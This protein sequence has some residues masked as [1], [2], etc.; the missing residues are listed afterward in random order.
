MGRFI[1]ADNYPSTG[2]DILGN[3]MFAYCNNNPVIYRDSSGNALDTVIDV[4]SLFSSIVA[5]AQ[6]PNDPWAWVGLAGDLV[7]VAIPFVGGI[8]ETVKATS[9][10]FKAADN[11][12][13][14]HDTVKAIDFSGAACFVAGTTVLAAG[15][16]VAI[17]NIHAGDYVWAWD[18]ETGEKSLRRVTE[19]YVNQTSELVH[20][21]VGG[22][23]IVTT[24]THPFY[25]PVKGW[26][27][28]AQLRAGDI[29]VLVNGEYVVVEKVQHELLESPINVYN[30]QVA[31]DH[32]Y[33]VSDIGVLVHNGCS[34]PSGSYEIFG[35]KNGK[36]QVY[37]G[38]GLETRMNVSIRRLQKDGYQIVDFLWEH[39][40]D[41]AT[42]FVQEYMKMAK[43][44]FDFGGQMINQIM[45]PGFKIFSSW[46]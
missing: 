44:N 29:L 11:F 10:L 2:Q 42:A 46:L 38:K 41:S 5:V 20:V 39:A 25:S 23:E 36:S 26:T 15:G 43:Y 45:S 9:T 31:G 32:T 34:K 8:G 12:D 24:P 22:E 14:V 17:E 19:T 30:F 28:A 4:I 7:D 1:N 3:N 27:D 37:V 40:D 16:H 21:F 35:T 13:D 6:N 33:Y 18:E